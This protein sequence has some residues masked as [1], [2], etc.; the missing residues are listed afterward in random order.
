MTNTWVRVMIAAAVYLCGA[1]SSASADALY[2]EKTPVKTASEATCLRFAGDTARSL[3]F[4]NG[5]QNPSEVAGVKNGVYVSITCVGRGQQD[6]IA[7][8]MAVGS[9][10]GLAQQV[11][12]QVA[13]KVKGVVCFDSPC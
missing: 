9:N 2:F 12:H 3:S 6:A 4:Q 13:D 10:F 11:G 7:V 8:V 5:H 1:T